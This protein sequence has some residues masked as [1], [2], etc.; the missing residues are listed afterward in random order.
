MALNKIV[1][2]PA[3]YIPNL[4]L[5]SKYQCVDNSDIAIWKDKIAIVQQLDCHLIGSTLNGAS[6]SLPECSVLW[7]LYT[8]LY[9]IGVH[10]LV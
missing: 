9:A 7:A 2:I 5:F 8:P 4:E 6:D 10:P 3:D 1:A